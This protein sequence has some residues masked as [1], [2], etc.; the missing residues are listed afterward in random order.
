MRSYYVL[1][2]VCQEIENREM[3]DIHCTITEHNEV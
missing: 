2:L 3:I 1:H